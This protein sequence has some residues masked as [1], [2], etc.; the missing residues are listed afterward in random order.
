MREVTV[1][2]A[3][4]QDEKKHVLCALRSPD[5]MILPNYWEFP[6]GKVEEGEDFHRA[7]V[8]EIQ[9]ELACE[10]V[11]AEKIT[12]VTHDYDNLRVHLH[13]YLCKIIKGTPLA[14]E[15]AKLAWLPLEQLVEL[16]FAPADIPTIH[17]ILEP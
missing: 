4:I 1:V 13:T 10:I 11:V 8:R 16:N 14:L 7:L 9:E 12:E 15:H 5:D 2:G 3:V 6:G 17:L